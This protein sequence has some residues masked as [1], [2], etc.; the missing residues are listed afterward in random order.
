MVLKEV[1]DMTWTALRSKKGEEKEEEVGVSE[2]EGGGLR[3]GKKGKS[4]TPMVFTTESGSHCRR[5]GLGVTRAFLAEPEVPVQRLH[6]PPEG[7]GC[8][9]V[10]EKQWLEE[11]SWWSQPEPSSCTAQHT[12]HSTAQKR[13]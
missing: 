3:R 4:F 8:P 1:L 10:K 9:V 12:A 5:V 11:S 2:E 6:P 13:T 7:R